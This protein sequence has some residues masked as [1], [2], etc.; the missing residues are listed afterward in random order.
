MS[1]PATCPNC[2]G[3]HWTRT[4]LLTD[5]GLVEHRTAGATWACVRCGTVIE[6]AWDELVKRVVPTITQ[7]HND[8][9]ELED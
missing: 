5:T 1:M 4:E 6:F 8:P 3:A 2:A 7:T 9:R